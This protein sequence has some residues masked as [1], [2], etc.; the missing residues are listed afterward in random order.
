[1]ALR[2]GATVDSWDAVIDMDDWCKGVSFAEFDHVVVRDA[3]DG[4]LALCGRSA[5]LHR[6][7]GEVLTRYQRFLPRRNAPSCC[8]SGS[9]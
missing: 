1:V 9:T 2:L 3:R 7:A 5:D 4:G 6:S 8:A